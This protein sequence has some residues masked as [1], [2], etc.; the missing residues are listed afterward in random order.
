M[1]ILNRSLG[2]SQTDK[3]LLICISAKHLTLC[4]TIV[5]FSASLSA[6][7]KKIY[8][9][10]YF[11]NGT[12]KAE[13]WLKN[14]K[15]TAYWKFYFQNGVVEKEGHYLKNKPSGYWYFYN[16]NGSKNSEGHFKDG[17]KTNWWL[18]Y[19]DMEKIDHKCQ[20]KR[21][22]KNGYCLMYKNEK[23]VSASKFKA[24]KK[25]KEWTDLKAFKKENDLRDLLN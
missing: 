10:A 5:L 8:Q 20:L 16:K 4:L 21:S 12:L 9:K 25:I 7:T 23:L 2:Q 14:N 6:Q 24:G 1:L 13:G 18:F 11:S 19:D 3:L 17:E 22:Q 15:K